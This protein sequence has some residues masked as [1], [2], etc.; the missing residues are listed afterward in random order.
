MFVKRCVILVALLIFAPSTELYAKS[1]GT[2]PTNYPGYLAFS[3]PAQL[4]PIDT[5]LSVNAHTKL[6]FSLIFEPL[7]RMESNR[8][9]PVLAQSWMIAPDGKSVTFTLNKNHFF[10]DG[11]EVTAQ[12]VVNSMLRLCSSNSQ[13]SKEVQGILGC[14]NNSQDKKYHPQVQT[15]DKYH[16]KFYII[17]SPNS[18]LY[19]LT[20]FNTGIIKNWNGTVLGSGPY[21]I[22]EKNSYFIALKKNPH[23]RTTNINNLGILLFHLNDQ[24]AISW[25]QKHRLDGALMYRS[26][27]I[28]NFSDNNYR[29]VNSEKNIVEMFVF[30]NQ[31]YPFNIPE[32]RQAL[33]ADIYNN[34][35]ISCITG[36]EKAY[37]TIPDGMGGSLDNVKNIHLSQFSPQQLFTIVPALKLKKNQSQ[38]IN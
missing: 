14:E 31:K 38:S 18:F 20:S 15:L 36:T 19:Q 12:D 10:S 4:D 35:N 28:Q 22:Q 6:L 25:L 16:V 17:G 3:E 8:I 5:T 9:F 29:I 24:D 11:T 37:G 34:I 33:S 27:N 1:L 2:F 30:N 32:V 21:E 23:Y 13:V 7:I 26:Q